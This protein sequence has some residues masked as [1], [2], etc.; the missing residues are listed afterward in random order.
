MMESGHCWAM[1]N[2]GQQTMVDKGQRWTMK[3]GGQ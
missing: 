3:S 1:N 2:G